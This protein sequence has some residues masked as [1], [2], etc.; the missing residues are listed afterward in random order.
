VD[1]SFSDGY[2]TCARCGADLPDG[3][4]FCPDCGSDQVRGRPM[5]PD[6]RARRGRPW[7]IGGVVAIG[8]MTV[9][10][11]VLVAVILDRP[12]APAAVSSPPSASATVSGS[13][14]AQPAPTASS[15]E[16]TSPTP[17]PAPVI[18]NAEVVEVTT[19]VL[20]IR[21][22]PNE[23]AD[24][25]STHGRGGRLFIIGEP[26]D[27]G[28]LRWYRIGTILPPLCLGEC[29][30]FVGYVATPLSGEDQW[31]E[32]IDLDCPASPMSAD[33]LARLARLEALS[34]YGRRDIVVRGRFVSVVGQGDS[35]PIHYTPGWLADPF[36]EPGFLEI[37][38]G[39]AIGFRPHPDSA[40]AAEMP[41][42]GAALTVTGHFEDAAATSCRASLEAEASPSV[43]LP[44]PA[45]T[46]LRCRG[47]FVWT[48]YEVSE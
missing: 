18:G 8:V 33:D 4:S 14:S 2:L 37:T 15:I 11:G 45:L 39:V 46:V 28:D 21:A 9:V 20:N 23:S 26:T 27:A 5:S 47:Q 31:L 25:L 12:S 13:G 29:E 44:A 38:A 1:G 34:C 22:A 10:A 43:Q 16:T 3:A 32:K 6:T 19:D 41:P 30:Q 24:I 48:V 17:E 40:A 42:V 7:L 35:G 36:V